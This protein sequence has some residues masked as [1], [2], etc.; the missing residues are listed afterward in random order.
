MPP[1][2]NGR[3]WLVF[4]GISAPVLEFTDERPVTLQFQIEKSARPQAKFLAIQIDCEVAPPAVLPG[5]ALAAIDNALAN[6][7]DIQIEGDAFLRPFI[8]KAAPIAGESRA[9]QEVAGVWIFRRGIL[10]HNPCA[11][12]DS[13]QKYGRD[14][15]CGSFHRCYPLN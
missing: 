4:T 8:T 7:G 5:A 13:E 10:R 3:I 1:G 6:L 2:G 9:G 14:N 11:K 12:R 15:N